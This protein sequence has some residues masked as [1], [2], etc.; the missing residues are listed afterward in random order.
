MYKITFRLF[1][2][3][4]ALQLVLGSYKGYVALFENGSNEPRQIYPYKTVTLPQP[5]QAALAE[6]IPVRSD[7]HLQQLLEDYLS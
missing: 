3:V 2:C 7:D 6:G 4:V 5:D 1:L